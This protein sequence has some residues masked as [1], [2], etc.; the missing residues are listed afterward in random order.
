M[1]IELRKCKEC[2][3]RKMGTLRMVYC[4]E[5]CKKKAKRRRDK[6]KKQNEGETMKKT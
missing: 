2:G 4:S 6:E 1:S 5:A 3:K